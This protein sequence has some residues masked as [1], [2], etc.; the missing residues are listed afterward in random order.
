MPYCFFAKRSKKSAK[1]L[2]VE[3]LLDDRDRK[4]IQLIKEKGPITPGELLKELGIPRSAFYRRI[5]RLV[6]E[7]LVEQ[8]TVGGKTYYKI[9]GEG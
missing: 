7:G 3:D 6:K 4:I 8:F 9:K 2:D 5:N 1:K